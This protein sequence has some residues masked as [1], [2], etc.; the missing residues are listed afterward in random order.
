MP[1]E[2]KAEDIPE[3]VSRFGKKL[4]KPVSELEKT[5]LCRI[6]TSKSFYPVV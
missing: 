4:K 3:S 1:F 2:K 5:D 6:V